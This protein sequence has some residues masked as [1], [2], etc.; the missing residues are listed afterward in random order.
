M[1]KRQLNKK[2]AKE[3]NAKGA[4]NRRKKGDQLG[5]VSRGGEAKEPSGESGGRGGGSRGK[6]SRKGTASIR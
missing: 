4:W 1:S 2:E 3:M 5:T 6:T